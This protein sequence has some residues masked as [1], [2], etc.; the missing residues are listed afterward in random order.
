MYVFIGLRKI[1]IIYFIF[2]FYRFNGH[3][4]SVKIRVNVVGPCGMAVLARPVTTL[5]RR[6]GGRCLSH[7]LIDWFDTIVINK[8]DLHKLMEYRIY[9]SFGLLSYF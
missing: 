6:S 4:Y 8:F 9:F 2:K 3:F 5:A 1:K 7:A